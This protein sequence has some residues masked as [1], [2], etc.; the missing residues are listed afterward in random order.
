MRIKV[1]IQN[2]HCGGGENTIINRLSEGINISD[3]E[4]SQEH[5]AVAF[6]YHT[7]H[8]FE[9]AKHP[10][11]RIGYPIVGKENKLKTKPRS[12][13]SFVFGKIKK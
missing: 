6:D 1:H 10:L 11:S 2:L 5:A 8:D 3:V 7:N 9:A 4:I 12:Y 13:L